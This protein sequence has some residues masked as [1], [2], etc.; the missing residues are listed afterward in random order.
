MHLAAA[1]NV[2]KFLLDLKHP[3][4]NQ[5]HHLN[6]TQYSP[7]NALK[8]PPPLYRLF[9][10]VVTLLTILFGPWNE[11]ETFEDDTSS[12]TYSISC[13]EEST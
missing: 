1:I 7:F 11:T 9:N 10:S 6:S 4:L 8:V 5:H 2:F 13:K 12:S 3:S